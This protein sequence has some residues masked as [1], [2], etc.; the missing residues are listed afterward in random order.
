MKLM[1]ILVLA[2]FFVSCGAV[3][4]EKRR[5]NKGFFIHWNNTNKKDC[6]TKKHQDKITENRT[7]V[8][9]YDDQIGDF[10][11]NSDYNKG[12]STTK[13][14][15]KEPIELSNQS[16]T[17]QHF[18]QISDTILTASSAL[19]NSSFDYNPHPNMNNR[20]RINPWVLTSFI[21]I[22]V[23]FILALAYLQFYSEFFLLLIF[24]LIPFLLVS[25]IVGL[26]QMKRH[27]ERY[28][29]HWMSK[30][31]LGFLLVPLIIIGLIGVA[32]FLS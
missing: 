10:A 1:Y 6:E 27:P 14:R 28:R 5:F 23:C 29:E 25:S 3:R 17:V 9:I 22:I 15:S 19:N 12:D 24:I 21:L 4:I 16:L 11:D 8:F 26:S 7:K 31:I 18:S 13:I 32:L 2:S 20:G 30:F